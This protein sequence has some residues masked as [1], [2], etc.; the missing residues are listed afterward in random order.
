MRPALARLGLGLALGLLPLSGFA[1][2]PSQAE[3]EAASQEA[4]L[5]TQA[6]IGPQKQAFVEA[7]LALTPE[8]LAKFRPIYAGH[9][10]AL[11]RF[12]QRRLDNVVEYSRAYNDN[13][14]SDE[15]AHKLALEAL[16]IEREETFE[17][18]M[19][20]GKVR[21]AIPPKKAVHYLQIESKLRAL[22][23][24]RQAESVPVAKG[25]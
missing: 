6:K 16:A 14:L 7:Q 20:Y 15:Q 22:V 24:F 19:V 11:K 9:Q 18:E 13:S 25:R 8:Q 23:R 10:E 5:A 4:L 2:E 17:L 12:N 3:K 1:Q 21:T